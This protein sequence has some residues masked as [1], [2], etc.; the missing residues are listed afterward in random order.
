MRFTAFDTAWG[1][2]A[3]G[4]ALTLALVAL[5]RILS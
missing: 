4:I 2:L 5:L 1:T 3:L